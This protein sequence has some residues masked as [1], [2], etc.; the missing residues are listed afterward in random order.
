[1]LVEYENALVLVTDMK[2]EAVKDIIP[3]LEQVIAWIR[4]CAATRARALAEG[5]G[6]AAWHAW[7]AP[8][9]PYVHH[10]VARLGTSLTRRP[11]ARRSPA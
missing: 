1:M 8:V 6:G 4:V 2:I 10:N 9:R 11:A 7:H 5:G 3:I